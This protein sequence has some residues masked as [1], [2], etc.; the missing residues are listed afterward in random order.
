MCVSVTVVLFGKGLGL[1]WF[2]LPLT[3]NLRPPSDVGV[4]HLRLVF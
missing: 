1:N 3:P 2:P 4:C